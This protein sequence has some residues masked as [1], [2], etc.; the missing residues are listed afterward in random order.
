M[1]PEEIRKFIT[2]NG[3]RTL[4]ELRAQ[5]KGDSGLLEMTLTFLV[6]RTMVRKIKVQLMSGCE[7]IYYIPCSL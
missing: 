5:F 4:S 7:D 3:Y 6:E 1:N 2:E